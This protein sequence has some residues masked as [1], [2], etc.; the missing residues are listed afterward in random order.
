MRKVDSEEPRSDADDEPE[1]GA[2]DHPP[3][4]RG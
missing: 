4:V 3:T 2:E 1:D